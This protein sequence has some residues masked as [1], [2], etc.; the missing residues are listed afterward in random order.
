MHRWDADTMYDIGRRLFDKVHRRKMHNHH[1]HDIHFLARD[2]TW[3]DDG[4]QTLLNGEYD[5]RCLKR[6]YFTDEMVDQLHISDRIFQ[7]I[8]LKIIKPTFK[9][10]GG[11]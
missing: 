8:L 4:I 9:R 10:F 5:P 1:N 7:H 6:Y 11:G 3:L 2:M